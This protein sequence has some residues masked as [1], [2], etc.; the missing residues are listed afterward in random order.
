MRLASG[1]RRCLVGGCSGQPPRECANAAQGRSKA[2]PS[3][4]GFELRLPGGAAHGGALVASR[5]ELGTLRSQKIVGVV[6]GRHWRPGHGGQV[7]VG[8]QWTTQS[9]QQLQQEEP[10]A[11][12]GW[13]RL[14]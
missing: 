7:R 3:T 1:C 12:S 10:D 2:G 14:A 4:S 13:Q 6:H 5:L 9:V 11:V 8:P